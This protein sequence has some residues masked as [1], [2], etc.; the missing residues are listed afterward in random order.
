[1]GASGEKFA[2]APG[3]A[4]DGVGPRHADDVKAFGAGGGGEFGF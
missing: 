4:R 2:Q 1:M 3:G